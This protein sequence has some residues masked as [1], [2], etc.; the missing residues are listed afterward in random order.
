M[1]KELSYRWDPTITD[2]SDPLVVL[3]KLNALIADKCNYN[4][5]K[6]VLET[7]PLTVSQTENARPLF[8]QLGYNMK[9]YRAAQV[10]LSLKWGDE[11]IRSNTS[12]SNYNNVYTIP[13][14]TMFSDVDGEHVFTTIEDASIVVD[15]STVTTCK[16]LQGTPVKLAVGG[17]T[18]ITYTNL[19]ANNRIYIP[20]YNVAENGIFISTIGD[21]EDYDE[22]RKVDNLYVE[23]LNQ[24]IYK[25]GVD[26][27]ERYCY[28]EFPED[29]SSV[30][31]KGINITYIKTDG[32]D[33]SIGAN[34]ISQIYSDTTVSGYNK[35]DS[36][37]EVEDYMFTADNL[38]VANLSGS[39][40]GKDPETIV[41][42]YKNY[43]KV[44]GTFN[45]LVSI[46]DYINYFITTDSVSNCFVC[47]RMNDIQTA[48][49]IMSFENGV[50]KK[51]TSWENK[52]DAFDLKLYA[53][54]YVDT[55]QD[56]SSYATSFKILPYYS[57][58]VNTYKECYEEYSIV[59]PDFGVFSQ[60]EVSGG[61]QAV[62]YA[63]HDF[64]PYEDGKI[65]M[66]KN[67]YPLTINIVP[68]YK[69][70]D[71]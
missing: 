23:N 32:Y 31:K 41:D 54:Q 30:M 5:D 64:I 47:D 63:C 15:G 42:A 60:D 59:Q 7:S 49:K 16:A 61:V 57:D 33:G 21:G 2:E 9:W 4:I 35:D 28:I 51:I 62:R 56:A 12:E 38:Y 55:A 11:V 19:D 8:E 45:T 29:I 70:T 26:R 27:R 44:A 18:D 20:D 71:I 37:A 34:A 22:W 43:K 14:F 68:Q 1:V 3:L 58:N 25:F 10:D 66:L 67:K 40:G 52:L 53:L 48:Y 69:L 46:R 24:K 65:L 17:N 36:T 13:R 6:N 50:Y 39:V